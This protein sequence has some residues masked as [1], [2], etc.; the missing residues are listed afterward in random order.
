MGCNVKCPYLPSKK[1]VDWGLE[2]PSGKPEDEFIYTI[3][4]IENKLFELKKELEI[5]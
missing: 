5:G 1:R 2:D 4:I 3:K